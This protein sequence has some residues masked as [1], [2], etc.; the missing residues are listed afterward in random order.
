MKPASAKQKG[1]AFQQAIRDRLLKAYPE[2]TLDD[3]RSTSMGASGADLQLSTAAK[4]LFPYAVECKAR[5]S[6]KGLYDWVEQAKCHGKGEPLVVFK[7]D[8]KPPMVILSFEHFMELA[9]R[10]PKPTT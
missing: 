10:A 6:A 2:L 7:A 9:Q 1:R 4:K 5:K 8:R 3:V